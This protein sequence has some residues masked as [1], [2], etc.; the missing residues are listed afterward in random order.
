[1]KKKIILFIVLMVVIIFVII[2]TINVINI[3][4]TGEIKFNE[5]ASNIEQQSTTVK[6]NENSIQR[7]IKNNYKISMNLN[8]EEKSYTAQITV[9]FYNDS[10]DVWNSIFFRDYPSYFKIKDGGNLSEI[11]Q[12]KDAKT[13]RELNLKRDENDSTVFSIE[14]LEPLNP[15]EVTSISMNYKA[16]IPNFNSRFGYQK[17]DEGKYDFYLGN[18][19][20]IL[21]PYENGKFQYYPYFEVGEC[22][23][24]KIANYDVNIEVPEDYTIIATGDKEKTEKDENKKIEYYKANAVRDFAIMIGNNYKFVSDNVDGINLNAYFHNG[25]EK[26]GKEEIS[27]IKSVMEKFNKKL[28]KYPYKQFNLVEAKMEMQGMEYP[29][30]ILINMEKEGL[31]SILHEEIHQWFYNIVGNN[32]YTSAWLDESMTT[33]LSNPGLDNHNEEFITKGYD[34]YTDN[35]NY[36]L[37]MYFCGASMY[38]RLEENNGKNKINKLIE[39]LLN[40]YSYSEITTQEMV[41]LLVKYYGKNNEILKEYIEPTYLENAQD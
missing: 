16:Y 8:L 12:I 22:F 27:K 36:T 19:L 20:P 15:Q 34:K 26:E 10:T 18:S 5:D 35:G 32:S 13:G 17:L 41:N 6:W 31:E 3:K 1:M 25:R 9:S 14:L 4:N 39:E 11:T 33:Y 21:C 37:A 23:Y 29:E 2:A 30:M 40:K 28:G 7:E 24:S 38:N